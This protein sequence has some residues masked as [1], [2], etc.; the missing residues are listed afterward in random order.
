ML[1]ATRKLVVNIRRLCVLLILIAH[2]FSNI[3]LLITLVKY[4]FSNNLSQK[5]KA[6]GI[7]VFNVKYP[8]VF[9]RLSSVSL[10]VL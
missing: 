7:P 10:A 4:L 3:F 1:V 9:K 2:R 5:N 6:A 8:Y